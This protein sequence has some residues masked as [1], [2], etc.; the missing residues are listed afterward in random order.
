MSITS[1]VSSGACVADSEGYISRL[2]GVS[3]GAMLQSNDLCKRAPLPQYVLCLVTQSC[4]P[5]SSVYGI[6]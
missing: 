6:L 2:S 1:D 4:P 5:G 3:G